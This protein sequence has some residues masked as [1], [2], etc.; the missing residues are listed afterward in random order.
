MAGLLEYG[1]YRLSVSKIPLLSG[2]IP[3]AKGILDYDI[4]MQQIDKRRQ[5]DGNFTGCGLRAVHG[6]A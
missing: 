2:E 1:G 4:R 3:H 5:D 6:G